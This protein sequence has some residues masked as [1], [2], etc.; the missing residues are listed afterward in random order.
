VRMTLVVETG[1]GLLGSRSRLT[2]PLGA[3]KTPCS[4]K[5]DT[6]R[7]MSQENVDFVTG[8]F[9]ATGERRGRAP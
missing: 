7:A 5:R 6:E 1:A 8:L 3:P 2:V 9:D 4:S